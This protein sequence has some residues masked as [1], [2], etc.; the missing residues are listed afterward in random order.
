MRGRSRVART[1]I[2]RL[3]ELGVN[4]LRRRY[5]E[6]RFVNVAAF[7]RD[8]GM[9]RSTYYELAGR[10]IWFEHDT[11]LEKLQCLGIAVSDVAEYI[12]YREELSASDERRAPV[13]GN[14]P[15]QP[16]SFVGREKEIA[17]VSELAASNPLITLTGA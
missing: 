11:V 13:P 3:N 7:C 5:R 9:P 8:V 17:A 16:T 2:C 4:L 12:E 1:G 14:L 6:G 10:T 15:H